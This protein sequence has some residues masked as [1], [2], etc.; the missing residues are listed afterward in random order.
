MNKEKSK[1]T[2][3]LGLDFGKVIM[4]AVINGRQD[5]S[6]LGTTFDEAMKS[7]ATEGA[8]E[9]VAE[10]VDAFKGNVWIVSKCG[11]SV[12][13][14]TRAWLKHNHFYRETGLKN[15]NLR[16]CRKRPEKAPICQQI[17]ITAFVDDRLDVLIHMEGIVSDLYLFGEQPPNQSKIDSITAVK[18]W[19]EVLQEILPDKIRKFA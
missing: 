2:P 10:L 18:D 5:T 6:F 17:G 8:I 16:F 1:V 12:E 15:A 13:N 19:E 14:K 11:P 7:P 3:K 9:A 4:G